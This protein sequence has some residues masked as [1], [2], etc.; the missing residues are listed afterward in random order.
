[1]G[2]QND[3]RTT[4]R[5]L[6]L[7]VRLTIAAFLFSVGLGYLA[8]MVQLKIQLASAGEF[9]PTDKDV[10]GAYS[11][12]VAQSQF[13]RLIEAPDTRPFN[14]Q[15]S[16]RAA[17]TKKRSGG[18]PKAVKNKGKELEA[19]AKEEEEK[20]KEKGVEPPKYVPP[21]ADE[22][23]AAVAADREG[24]RLALIEWLHAGA[25]KKA[26]EEDKFKLSADLAAKPITATFVEGEGS[27]KSAKIRSIIQDRC[28]RCH[29]D[30]AGFGASQY[31]LT[32]WEE[33]SLYIQQEKGTGMSLPKLAQTSH[34]HL[35]GFAMLW[36]M[37]GFIF[38]LTSFPIWLR[39]I[40]APAALIGQMVDIS[41]WWLARVD[42][43]GPDFARAIKISG[44]V[45]GLALAIQILGSLFDLFDKKGKA[46]MAVI[47][48]VCAGLG[49]VIFVKVVDPYMKA[50]QAMTAKAK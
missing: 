42:T 18:W 11:G 24:E 35:L 33:I 41:F 15:G 48:L 6:S 4:L 31:P 21:T 44:G 28:V 12:H 39:V 17:F 19:K 20:A 9:P 30:G 37:T 32:E 47:L 3:E 25:D 8:A 50:E 13:E 36:G 26:F 43:H 27:G 7:P 45:V 34:V 16:M 2:I 40:V 22:L 10:I 49:G 38:A 5:D 23:D 1:M 46:V 29:A 14:G